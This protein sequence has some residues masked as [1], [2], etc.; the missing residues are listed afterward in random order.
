NDPV[1]VSLPPFFS[2][3]RKACRRQ[4]EI[5]DNKYQADRMSADEPQLKANSF[6]ALML[7]TPV[8]WFP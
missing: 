6:K 5:T 2:D 7:T 4:G 1:S 8:P 3:K